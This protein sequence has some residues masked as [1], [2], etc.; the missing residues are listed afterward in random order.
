MANWAFTSYAIEGPKETLQKIEQAIL[1]HDVEEGSSENW[2]GNILHALDIK[3]LDRSQDRENGKYMRGFISDSEPWYY[4]NTL[5][6][7][8]KE[9]WGITDFDEV[10]METFPDIKVYWVVEEPGME[11]Y[12]TNDKEGKYFKDRF[13]VDTC[14]EGNYQSEY[15]IYKSSVFKWLHDITNGRVKSEQDVEKFNSEY[16]VSDSMDE[17]FIYIHEFEIIE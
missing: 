5:R 16:E 4:N 2:E 8:A 9:A 3:W 12:Q 1:H 10:L 17:N 14:I 11:I 7:D 15:F 13:Y 6:F